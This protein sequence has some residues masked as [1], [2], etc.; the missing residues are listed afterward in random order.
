MLLSLG[1]SF[2]LFW[3]AF[4]SFFTFP[5]PFLTIGWGH[6]LWPAA[7]EKGYTGSNIVILPV[8]IKCFGLWFFYI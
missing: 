8:F 3:E 1:R 7:Y 2:C 6:L 4:A 5:P